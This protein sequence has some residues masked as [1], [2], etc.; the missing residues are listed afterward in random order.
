MI[1]K[2]KNEQLI[3]QHESKEEK[4]MLYQMT[5]D[6]IKSNDRII[7]KVMYT[8]LEGSHFY[9]ANCPLTPT[10]EFNELIINLYSE[11][12]QFIE[13]LTNKITKLLNQ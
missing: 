8:S 7:D 5:R 12:G 3:L 4:T 2:F 9:F 13:E 1:V 6:I 11:K 10:D